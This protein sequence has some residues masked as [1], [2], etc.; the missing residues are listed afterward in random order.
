MEQGVRCFIMPIRSRGSWL[1]VPV[2]IIFVGIIFSNILGSRPFHFITRYGFFASSG[3]ASMHPLISCPSRLQCLQYEGSFSKVTSCQKPS[4]TS[5]SIQILFGKFFERSTS[6]QILAII[7]LDN[8][9]I[10]ASRVRCLPIHDLRAN[11]DCFL[12]KYKGRLGKEIQT[13]AAG[14]SITNRTSRLH[15]KDL[16]KNLSK[17]QSSRTQILLKSAT[18]CNI[19]SMSFG[20]RWPSA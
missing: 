9:A 16:I 11:K 17:N 8:W 10:E 13:R 5:H 14:D 20:S 2:T 4:I 12:N 3:C 7:G 18:S 19:I 6:M 1:I 15:L